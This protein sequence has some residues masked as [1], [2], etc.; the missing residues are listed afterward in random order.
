MSVIYADTLFAVNFSMD[1][2]SLYIAGKSL[3]SPIRPL[4][5][6][7]AAALGGVFATLFAVF[8]DKGTLAR[9]VWG[10]AFVGCTAGMCALAYS[11]RIIRSVAVFIAV[12]LGLGGMISAMCGWLRMRGLMLSQSLEPFTLLIFA[13]IAG[14]FSLVYRRL[15]TAKRREVCA[16]FTLGGKKR[17]LRLLVDS[18]NLLCE[19]ISR[20]P[21]I[22]VSPKAAGIGELSPDSIPP[23][24]A[25]KLRAIPAEGVTGKRIIYGF[26]SEVTVEGRSVEAVIAPVESDYGGLDGIIPE[27]LV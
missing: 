13:G 17:E 4:K 22:V 24:I 25:S 14:A 11:G 23:G 27:I 26:A 2:L 15:S 3:R 18:G 7:A 19:P 6:A 20:R 9:I 8:S 21:V 10:L 16:D 1:F 5:L 12:N